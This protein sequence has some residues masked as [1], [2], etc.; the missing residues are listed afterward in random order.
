MKQTRERGRLEDKDTALSTVASTG[1]ALH[2]VEAH[3]C[4][5]N[6]LKTA[7]RSKRRENEV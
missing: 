4:M 2:I 5:L 7:V 3:K 6:G 1:Q